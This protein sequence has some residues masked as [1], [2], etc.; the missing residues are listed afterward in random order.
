LLSE[1]ASI[2]FPYYKNDYKISTLV[3]IHVMIELDSKAQNHEN[4]TPD[5]GSV[6]DLIF[7]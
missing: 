7:N 1:K 6:N 4:A 2:H 5:K 3:G